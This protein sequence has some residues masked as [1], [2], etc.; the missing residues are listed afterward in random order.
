M[1]QSTY[2]QKRLLRAV[3]HCVKQAKKIEHVERSVRDHETEVDGLYSDLI[4]WLPSEVARFVW[5]LVDEDLC[6]LCKVSHPGRVAELIRMAAV[7]KI[8]HI[9]GIAEREAFE[10]FRLR[11]CEPGRVRSSCDSGTPLSHK[12]IARDNRAEVERKRAEMRTKR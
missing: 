2:R 6:R 11:K 4:S 10:L 12:A 9:E 7:D 1:T 3:D 8:E 5:V